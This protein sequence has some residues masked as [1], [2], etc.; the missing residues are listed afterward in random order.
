MAIT[1]DEAGRRGGLAVLAS[2]GRE[3]YAGIGRKGQ[4]AMRA[5]YP[6]SASEWGR[7]GGRPRKL[8][9]ER[10]GEGKQIV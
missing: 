8:P 2:R 6:N 3:F 5:K 10:H 7:K 9:F 1:V 4:K